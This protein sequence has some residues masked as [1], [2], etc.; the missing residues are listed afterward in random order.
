MICKVFLLPARWF[1]VVSWRFFCGNFRTFWSMIGDF[2]KQ[3][4]V[5]LVIF[6]VIKTNEFGIWLGTKKHHFFCERIMIVTVI[7]TEEPGRSYAVS[8]RNATFINL[9]VWS[10]D[11]SKH[12]ATTINNCEGSWQQQS[13]GKAR[14]QVNNFFGPSKKRWKI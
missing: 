1:P 4:L 11:F 2:E 13:S 10:R 5:I 3:Y 7:Y 14:Q 8:A 12:R 6:R 9:D